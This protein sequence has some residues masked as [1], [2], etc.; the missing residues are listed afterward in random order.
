MIV[1]DQIKTCIQPFAPSPPQIS[2]DHTR[3][4][5]FVLLLLVYSVCT[6]QL[7]QCCNGENNLDIIVL[8]MPARL[9]LNIGVQCSLFE[10]VSSPLRILPFIYMHITYCHGNVVSVMQNGVILNYT[11]THVHTCMSKTSRIIMGANLCGIFN[12]R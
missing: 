10:C 2:T 7:E 3:R 4:G 12:N 8:Y 9:F 6:E 11:D 1:V 5:L